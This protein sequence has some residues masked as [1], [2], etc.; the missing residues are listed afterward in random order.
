MLLVVGLG[1]WGGLEVVLDGAL[2]VLLADV[3]VQELNIVVVEEN[4]GFL[5]YWKMLEVGLKIESG[6]H[7]RLEDAPDLRFGEFPLVKNLLD[8]AI[9][10]L[11]K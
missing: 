3:R 4:C 9:S 6:G 2:H 1:F 7:N 5:D 8:C 10:V 11:K